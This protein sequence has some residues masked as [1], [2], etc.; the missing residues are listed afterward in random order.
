M[1]HM[2][3]NL[4]ND[5]LNELSKRENNSKFEYDKDQDVENFEIPGWIPDKVER[6]TPD[7]VQIQTPNNLGKVTRTP[8]GMESEWKNLPPE[9]LPSR[10][11]GYPEGFEIAIKSATV[12][13]IRHFSTVDDS[14]RIDLDDKLNTIIKKCMRIRW[15][16]GVLDHYDLW[17]EDRFFIIMSIRD[18]TFIKGENRI[19]LPISKN[20]TKAEC[21]VPDQIELKSNLLDSFIMDQEIIK[22]YD[23][24][25]FSFKFIP[26]DG[27]PEM[28]LYIPTVGVTTSC[29]KIIADKRAKGKKFDP[30]FANIATFI[31]PDWRSLDE[32]LYDQYERA[33]LEWTPL[34][35]SIADQISQKINFATK[36]RIYTKCESCGGEVT[37]EISFP[38]GYR[39]LF[40]ISNIFEQLL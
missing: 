16:G 7:P 35:F 27:S 1:E 10:G 8:L 28:N 30:S 12:S 14:D 37:A 21:Q 13:E 29:R 26:K 23:G 22:R 32:R 34:Q 33:S 17:Y 39:S 40:V 5:L 3:K 31:I 2:D 11:F 25:S 36:S 38:G 18:L 9:T 15:N 19:L 24:D 20:C 6:K 4:E